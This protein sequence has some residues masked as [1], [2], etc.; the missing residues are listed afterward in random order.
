M[1][2]VKRFYNP[3]HEF[4]TKLVVN[5]HDNLNRANT[6]LPMLTIKQQLFKTNKI[7]ENKTYTRRELMEIKAYLTHAVRDYTY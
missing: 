2:G 6:G 1:M 5:K 4:F 3:E 7:V